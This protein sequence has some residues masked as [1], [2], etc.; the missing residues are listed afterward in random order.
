MATPKE[1]SALVRVPGG[2]KTRSG[3]RTAS[4][5][6]RVAQLNQLGAGHGH[7]GGD[8]R[9]RAKHERLGAAAHG[10]ADPLAEP[11]G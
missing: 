6:I 2:T 11:D 10:G 5:L 4:G 1:S 9:W 8:E 3:G 7:L